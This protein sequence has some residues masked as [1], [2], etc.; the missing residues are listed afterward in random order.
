MSEVSLRALEPFDIPA[1][2]EMWRQLMEAGATADPRFKPASDAMDAVDAYARDVWLRR[3]PFP[4]GWVAQADARLVAFVL[5]LPLHMLPV[6]NRPQTSV[7][8]DIWVDPEWRRLGLGRRLVE[9]FVGAS[10][11]AG[12]PVFEVR[13]LQADGRAIAF[14]RGVGFGDWMVRL[15][16]ES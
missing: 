9:R 15:S 5:G 11:D 8:T 13:T 7:I 6:L 1:V 12:Y 10:R 16:R 14:W 3:F 2:K 4:H